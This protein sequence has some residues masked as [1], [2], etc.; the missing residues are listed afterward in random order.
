MVARKQL[1]DH[2]NTLLLGRYAHFVNEADIVPRVP[3]TFTHCGSLVWFT[4][5]IIK[6]SKPKHLFGATAT[7]KLCR[8]TTRKSSH[9]QSRNST[10][11]KLNCEQRMQLQIG[12]L[13]AGS[14]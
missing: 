13:T 9:F 1:A 3:P 10:G 14:S 2:L 11:S 4:G 5:G 12:F 7:L 6:R 8:K